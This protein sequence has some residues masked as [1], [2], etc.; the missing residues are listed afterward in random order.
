MIRTE[1]KA[2]EFVRAS[3][4]ERAAVLASPFF[5]HSVKASLNGDQSVPFVDEEDEPG[6]SD[7]LA[8]VTLPGGS[9]FPKYNGGLITVHFR[10]TRN[11]W[12]TGIFCDDLYD[13]MEHIR[14]FCVE[15]SELLSHLKF[16]WDNAFDTIF[17]T[18]EYLSEVLGVMARKKRKFHDL[19]EKPF[20]ALIFG[21][22][23]VLVFETPES[24]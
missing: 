8:A 3:G 17:N 7:F 20:T 23:E 1:V 12:S 18:D 10:D 19:K 15:D 6:L 5:S 4:Y 22:H 24:E 16:V 11:G 9:D 13:A 14:T 2:L 21:E